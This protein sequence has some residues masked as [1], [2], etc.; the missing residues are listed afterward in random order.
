MLCFVFS[1]SRAI[2]HALAENPATGERLLRRIAFRSLRRG[3][4]NV[5]VIAAEHPRCSAR[6]FH[7]LIWSSIPAIETA[8]ATNARASSLL[9]DR[10]TAGYS[11][12]RLRMDFAANPEAPPELIARLLT[13]RDPYVRRVAAAHPAATPDGLRRLCVDLSQPAWTLR[14]AATNA[15]CPPDLSDQLLTWLALGGAGASDPLFDP[16]ACSGYPGSTDVHPPMWYANAAR[17]DRAESH[18][19]WRVRAAIPVARP[20]IPISVL[21]LLALD[22]RTEV[23]RQAARFPALPSATLRELRFDTDPA[24]ARLAASALKDKRKKL[25]KR[26]RSRPTPLSLGVPIVLSLGVMLHQGAAAPSLPDLPAVGA[27]EQLDDGLSLPAAIATTR[28]VAGGGEIDSGTLTPYSLPS[29]PFLSVTAGTVRLTVTVPGAR[30]TG[31]VVTW[32]SGPMQVPAHHR[33]VV[34]IPTDPTSVVVTLL[35]PGQIPD[36]LLFTF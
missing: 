13:D 20:R 30:T 3:H 23:R 1:N 6:I 19:L 33:R 35:A 26:L 17:Q 15:S 27:L 2:D 18:P 22:P 7:R 10:L 32:E 8:V 5:A 24:V 12:A 11:E 29:L 28:T 4:W 14:A 21:R 34:V 16:I 25:R 36:T 31:A 9:M